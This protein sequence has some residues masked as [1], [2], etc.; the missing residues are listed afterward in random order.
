MRVMS[1]MARLDQLQLPSRMALLWSRPSENIDEGRR[2]YIFQICRFCT[3]WFMVFDTPHYVPVELRSFAFPDM[4]IFKYRNDLDPSRN[5]DKVARVGEHAVTACQSV[6][7]EFPFRREIA[8]SKE[9]GRVSRAVE[10]R[11][12]KERS[13]ATRTSE[14]EKR[15]TSIMRCI[16]VPRAFLCKFQSCATGSLY[17]PPR[18][19]RD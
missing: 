7:T 4:F 12:K 16:A 11:R 14:K 8:T 3:A 19:P 6:S 9:G 13:V 1:N 15:A 5:I 17:D 18:L 2:S 10:S